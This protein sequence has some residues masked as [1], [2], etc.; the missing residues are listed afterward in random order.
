M[1]RRRSHAVVTSALL[2]FLAGLCITP[3]V[4]VAPAELPQRLGDDAYWRLV[5]DFSEPGGSFR[6]DN[7]VSNETAFQHVI[8]ELQSTLPQGGVY[9]GVGPDQNFTYIAAL[10]PRMAFIV[11]IRRQNML[12]HL[13]YKAIVEQ[14]DDRAEFLSRLFSRKQ[15]PGIGPRST[16]QTLFEAYAHA[17]PSE[18][19]FQKELRSID[20]RLTKHHKFALSA[21]DLA[22]IEY[23]FRSFYSGGPDLR[24]S[25]PRGPY[26]LRI[27][28]TYAELMMETDGRGENRSYLATEANYRLLRE[29]QKN[30]L[31]VPIVGDFAGNKALRSVGG[32]VKEHSAIVSVFYTSNVEQYLFQGGTWRQF[33][34]NVAALPVDPSSRFV[35]AYFNNNGYPYPVLTPRPQMLPSAAIGLRSATLLD[36]IV[37]SLTAFR[38]GR[39][40]TYGDVIDRSK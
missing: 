2:V 30:N 25:F 38:D 8:P 32:Y 6:S 12:L 11:D 39:I 31:I 3:I 7:L 35:R 9:L 1:T 4:H 13:M 15:P 14:S 21:T 36:P 28:P 5:V 22:N 20:D 19:L 27:F 26:G 34:V 33:F 40:Q 23:I 17:E 24:Y 10:R 29:M 18:T 37:E 16:A